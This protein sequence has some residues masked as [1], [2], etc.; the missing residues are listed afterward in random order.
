MFRRTIM[1]EQAMKDLIMIVQNNN[2]K[3][4]KENEEKINERFD[5]DH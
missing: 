3:K 5:T 4:T 2:N 1:N